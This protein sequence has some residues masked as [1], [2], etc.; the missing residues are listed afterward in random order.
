M[1]KNVVVIGAGAMGSGIS[2]IAL[3]GGN[4][5]TLVIKEK[6]INNCTEKIRFGLEK[7]ESKKKLKKTTSKELLTHLSR[8]T[9]LAESV[10]NADLVVEA[11]TENLE[12]KK[13]LFKIAGENAPEHC[14]IVS[15]TSS[16]SIKALGEASGRPEKVCG[17]H[18]FIPAPLMRLVE[19]VRTDKR[20]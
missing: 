6:Y 1:I 10:K 8:S 5:V 18:F 12:I 17:A 14:I 13:E 20:L 7:L 3:M 19:I 4:D 16:M 11:V 2:Q 9:N 15:N